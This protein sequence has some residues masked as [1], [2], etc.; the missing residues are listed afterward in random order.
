VIRLNHLVI[1]VNLFFV[2][3]LTVFLFYKCR[4]ESPLP[5]LE[6]LFQYCAAVSVNLVATK[7]L[8][9]FLEFT[10]VLSFS[11]DSVFYTLMAMVSACLLAVLC[12]IG[13]RLQI[14]IKVSRSEKANETH[15]EEHTH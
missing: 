1:F 13:N 2:P 14:E 4:G 6:L 7:F 15:D 11:M 12:L 3:V 5:S 10:L 8:L 9:Y